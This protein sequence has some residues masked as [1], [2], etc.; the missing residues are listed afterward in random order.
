[1]SAGEKFFNSKSLVRICSSVEWETTLADF[2]DGSTNQ[3]RYMEALAILYGNWLRYEQFPEA[4][5]TASDVMARDW[6]SAFRRVVEELPQ[7]IAQFVGWWRGMGGAL[8]KE[9]LFRQSRNLWTGEPTGSI[10][11]PVQDQLFRI[12]G[13]LVVSLSTIIEEE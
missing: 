9:S 7:K 4:V 11:D 10:Q 13:Q 1:M 8:T 3:G 12:I 6:V 5:A 2:P